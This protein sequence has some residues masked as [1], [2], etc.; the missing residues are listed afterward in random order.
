MLITQKIYD[1][2]Q[3][4]Y[5]CVQ[6]FPKTE[7]HTMAAEIKQSMYTVLKLTIAANKKYHKKT[8]LQ[9]IDIELQF[10]RTMVRLASELKSAPA[11][12]PFL[13][14]SKYEHWSKQLNEIGR[15][16]GGWIQNAKQ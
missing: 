5:V 16:L 9:E 13:P 2:I 1:M 4:G 6:Q 7:R 10:L 15:M 12:S 8:T 3:Y 14:F 11:G